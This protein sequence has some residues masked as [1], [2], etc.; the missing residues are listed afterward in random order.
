MPK[1]TGD[2]DAWML[3]ELTDPQLAASYINAAISEDPNTLKVALGNVA[4]AHTMKRVAKQAGVARESLY[5]S[6]SEAGNPTLSNLNGILKA[7]GLKIA[8]IPESEQSSDQEP[9]PRLMVGNQPVQGSVSDTIKAHHIA[10]TIIVKSSNTENFYGVNASLGIGNLS[11]EIQ[12]G[13][14]TESF[15]PFGMI[16]PELLPLA[17]EV[18]QVRSEIDVPEIVAGP[19]QPYLKQLARVAGIGRQLTIY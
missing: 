6:L 5:T 16:T 15:D 1:R 3:D 2:F 17:R 9:Q 7:V 4:K 8:I 12:S 18:T 14:G 11:F 10:S 13:I 19:A